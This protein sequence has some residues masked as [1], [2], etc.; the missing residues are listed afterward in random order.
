MNREEHKDH[1]NLVFDCP[2]CQAKAGA[3]KMVD[4][5]TEAIASMKFELQELT[6]ALETFAD[7]IKER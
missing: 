2:F 5:V 4:R 6:N 7:K 1:K 3:L